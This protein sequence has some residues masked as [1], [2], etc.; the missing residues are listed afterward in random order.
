MILN[1]LQG[2]VRLDNLGEGFPLLIVY[3]SDI[4]RKIILNPNKTV[5]QLVIDALERNDGY[6]P[7]KPRSE[8]NKCMCKDFKE[9][10]FCVCGLYI[11]EEDGNEL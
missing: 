9:T 2:L 1:V 8:E 4:M 7:F 11:I 5:V 10:G 6:C 3:R